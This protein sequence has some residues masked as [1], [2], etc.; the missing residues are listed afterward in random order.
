M[1][2][3]DPDLVCDHKAREEMFYTILQASQACFTLWKKR[4]RGN[5]EWIQPLDKL[6][7][8]M[9]I[10]PAQYQW[11]RNLGLIF[12]NQRS[13]CKK[14]CLEAA[15]IDLEIN[16]PK[17]PYPKGLAMYPPSKM[18]AKVAAH[19]PNPLPL[20]ETDQASSSLETSDGFGDFDDYGTSPICSQAAPAVFD[21][22][23]FDSSGLQILPNFATTW[24]DRGYRL[25]PD[26]SKVSQKK[27]PTN[28]ISRLLPTIEDITDELL[29]TTEDITDEESAK[30]EATP[31]VEDH[32][33]TVTEAIPLGAK[34]MLDEAG[35]IPKTKGSYNVFVRGKTRADDFLQ[36]DLE[37]DHVSL[38]GHQVSIS[39][40]IDS[41]LWI[42][43]DTSLGFKGA[44]NLHLLPRF[45]DE[46]P[47][48][49]NPCVYLTLLGPPEDEREL[50][51]PHLRTKARYPLSS[52]PHMPFGYFGE[53]SQQFNLYIF[54]PRMIHKNLSNNRTITIMPQELQDL[55]FSEAFFK[56]LASA[57]HPYPGIGEYLPRS[58]E[59]I[60]RKT[61]DRARHPTIALT[62]DPLAS[63]LASIRHAVSQNEDL[64]SRFGSF[65]FALDARGIKLLSKQHR[66]GETAFQTLQ[67]I[68][69]G[70][71]WNYMQDRTKGELY[72]DLGVSFHPINTTEPM[73]GLW[74]LEVLRSSYALMGKST[75]NSKEYHHNTM[76]DYG[77]VKAQTSHAVMH[78]THIV[79]RISY[80]LHFECIRQPGQR[81]YIASL[82]NAIQCNQKYLDGCTRW[83]KALE[84]GTEQSYGVRDELRASAFVVLEHLQVVQERVRDPSV[85]CFTE[86]AKFHL[87]RKVP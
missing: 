11:V 78:H 82:D 76:R 14:C 27:D 63:L 2:S 66:P 19:L 16:E 1:L 64:L 54:F 30:L 42:T 23:T 29:P 5:K 61:A 20:T 6:I 44:V 31:S 41:V 57:L 40:D 81:S 49:S 47:F 34:Q 48:S 58:T 60:R 24:K 53:A 65:F 73:V 70:L 37:Q 71:D 36:L 67:R 75:G 79:K 7:D 69:P 74:R 12:L 50:I 72:L 87:G 46:A 55:W 52:I 45:A 33:A 28:Y 8:E 21:A 43:K 22:W 4:S 25:P 86:S 56:A 77:G 80:N 68:V 17:S 84:A 85:F 39:T 18:G 35:N 15:S 26:F 13:R 83:M 9:H 10:P 38:T 3:F 32:P 59:Q 62:P 51:N